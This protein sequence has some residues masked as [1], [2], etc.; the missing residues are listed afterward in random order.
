[1]FAVDPHFR[2]VI[3]WEM[4]FV[5]LGALVALGGILLVIRRLVPGTHRQA[6]ECACG[7]NKGGCHA[8]I[9]RLPVRSEI[10]NRNEGASNYL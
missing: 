6:A 9:G 3:T 2:E 4:L 7:H 1:M 8:S 10:R 5:V